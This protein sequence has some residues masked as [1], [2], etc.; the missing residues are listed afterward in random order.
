MDT[1]AYN[2]R[3]G[4]IV[5]RDGVDKEVTAVDG[6]DKGDVWVWFTDGPDEVY[7][8][9]DTVFVRENDRRTP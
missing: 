4:D 9:N 2:L 5:V 8:W 1:R 7:A 3:L 6:I